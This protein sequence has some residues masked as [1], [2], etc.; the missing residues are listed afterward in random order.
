MVCYYPRSVRKV[1]IRKKNGEDGHTL[2]FIKRKDSYHVRGYSNPDPDILQIACGQCIGCRLARSREWALRCMHEA[3]LYEDNCFITLTYS[4]RFL[5]SDNSLDISHFQKFMKRLRKRCGNGIR[6]Y[7]CGEYGERFLRPH[8]HACL[9]NFDF[10]DKELFK[11]VNEQRLYV[12]ELL[13]DLWPFGF[14][15]VGSL[16]FESAAYV[17]R[18][19]MKKMYGADAEEHYGSRKPEYT[20]MSRKPGIGKGWFDKHLGDVY[21]HDFVVCKKGYKHKPPK[22]YD[23]QFELIYPDEFEILKENR[24]KHASDRGW[25]NSYK[26]LAVKEKCKHSHLKK[27]YRVLDS[28]I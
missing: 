18:Y 28:E 3:S 26:R 11:I 7:H 22:F 27:L 25:E 24:V 4:D 21:P 14:S 5:P 12:S 8:Y 1:K 16:T 6:F 9:F 2:D 20:T 13:S 23:S 19:I 17:A 10:E 15:T